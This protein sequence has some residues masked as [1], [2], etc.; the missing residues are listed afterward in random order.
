MTPVEPGPLPDAVDTGPGGRLR[1]VLDWLR[2]GYPS[3]VPTKDYIPLLALLRRRLTEDEVAQVARQVAA[4]PG[5]PGEREPD[6]G[7]LI[8]KITDALPTPE[9]IARVESHLTAHHAWPDAAPPDGS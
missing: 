4:Q 5:G 6:V 7:V 2:A 9:D 1:A 8:T 3:G